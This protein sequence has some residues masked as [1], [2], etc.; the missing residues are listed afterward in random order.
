MIGENLTK[1]ID[2]LNAWN[3]KILNKPALILGK[4]HKEIYYK[5]KDDIENLAAYETE[6]KM[7]RSLSVRFKYL[8]DVKKDFNNWIDWKLK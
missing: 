8:N 5:L 1:Y 2:S 3:V 6:P 4:D 7:Q